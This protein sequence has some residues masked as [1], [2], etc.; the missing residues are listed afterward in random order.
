[1]EIKCKIYFYPDQFDDMD[2][3]CDKLISEGWV[4]SKIKEFRVRKSL[5]VMM[6]NSKEVIMVRT[7]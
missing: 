1:M 7:I 6:I 5:G 3:I 2:E 4:L